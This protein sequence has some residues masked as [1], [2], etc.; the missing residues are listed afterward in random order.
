VPTT[1]VHG[2]KDATVPVALA[3]AMAKGIPGATLHIIA[4]EGHFANV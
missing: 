1:I 4:G 2:E 3:D